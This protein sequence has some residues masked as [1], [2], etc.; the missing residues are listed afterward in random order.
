[1]AF[2]C[3]MKGSPATIVPRQ[4]VQMIAL[5]TDFVLQASATASQDLTASIAPST[6]VLTIVPAM[7]SASMGSASAIR[8]TCWVLCA[9]ALSA[10]ATNALKASAPTV[11]A[12]VAQDGGARHATSRPVRTIVLDMD[13]ARMVLASVTWDTHKPTAVPKSALW[14]WMTTTNL[15]FVQAMDF[16]LKIRFAY[17]TQVLLV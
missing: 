14:V 3:A 13:D 15:R 12:S 5:E 1:M 7:E 11:L 17:A 4:F 2:V 16:V 8:V 9:I 10:R 6:H